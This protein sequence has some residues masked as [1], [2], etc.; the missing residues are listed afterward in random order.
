[1]VS[2]ESSSS[3]VKAKLVVN[4]NEK[5]SNNIE[6]VDN[7]VIQGDCFN[8]LLKKNYKWWKDYDADEDSDQYDENNPNGNIKKARIMKENSNWSI[9]DMQELNSH[10]ITVDSQDQSS[11][12]R[13]DI[14]YKA[15]DS[16]VVWW[17]NKE[18]LTNNHKYTLHTT[19]T[20]YIDVL[21][22]P[23]TLEFLKTACDKDD[24]VQCMLYTDVNAHRINYDQTHLL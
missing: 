7:D 13:K 2:A 6:N 24:L 9:E 1:V 19:Q 12:K 22:S 11:Y 10:V 18:K 23:E 4:N 17:E 3:N 21:C 20:P 5:S 8:N 15:D 14:V 16:S